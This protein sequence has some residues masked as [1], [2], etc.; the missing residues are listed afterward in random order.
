MKKAILSVLFL[1]VTQSLLSQ[2][3]SNNDGSFGIKGGL[4]YSTVTKG[5]FDEGL[6]PRTSFY[7]GFFGE[8]PLVENVFSIQPEFIYSRQG[9]ENNFSLL[10]NNYKTTYKIDY[11]NMPILAKIYL[12]DVFA[13][14]AGPQF[15]LKI[16]ENIESD[17]STTETNDVNS[18]DTALAGGISLNFDD[19]FI[20]GRYTYSLNEVVKDSNAKNSVF[21]VGLGFKF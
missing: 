13:I 12:G 2:E 6:D 14:E 20:S 17:N 9:F 11:I 15:G 8:I 7:L 1:I 21:Q 19:I 18:F 16:N 4:N 10:G 5:D 3:N